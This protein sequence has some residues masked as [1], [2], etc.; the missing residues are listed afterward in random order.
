M[1]ALKQT[2]HASLTELLDSLLP[3]ITPANRLIGDIALVEGSDGLDALMIAIS[4]QKLLGFHE[5][6]AGLRVL[7]PEQPMLGVWRV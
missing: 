4:G 6:G 1:R 7:Q 5:D 2:G 3:R